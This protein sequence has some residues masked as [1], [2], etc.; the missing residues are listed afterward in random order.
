[1]RV[2]VFLTATPY[3]WVGRGVDST[4]TLGPTDLGFDD[5]TFSIVNRQSPSSLEYHTHV[6]HCF[7]T[8]PCSVR[9]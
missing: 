5:G 9:V 3:T 7:N 6:D 2:S 4:E 8:Y 1:M